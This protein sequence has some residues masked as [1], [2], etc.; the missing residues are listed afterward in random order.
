VAPPRKQTE[1]E[2]TNFVLQSRK[3]PIYSKRRVSDRLGNKRW[4]CADHLNFDGFL[5]LQARGAATE[6]LRVSSPPS[7][8][9]PLEAQRVHA[10][11]THDQQGLFLLNFF[12][13]IF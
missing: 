5:I 7:N 12:F 9:R 3:T 2:N 6:T 1:T 10:K 8:L 4:Y 13:H 11:L